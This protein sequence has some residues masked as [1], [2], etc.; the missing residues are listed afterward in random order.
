MEINF[1]GLT[2]RQM[3]LIG[4]EARTLWVGAGT[5]TGKTVAAAIW[6]AIG[7]LAGEPTAWCGPWSARTRTGYKKVRAIL[8]P[9]IEAGEINAN[10]S[11]MRL[12]SKNGGTFEPFTGDNPGAIYGDGIKRFVIDE[13]SRQTQDTYTAAT[14]TTSAAKGSIRLLFNLDLGGQNWA[15]ENLL[16]VQAASP[17]ERDRASEDFMLFPTGDGGLVDDEEI[18]RVRLSGMPT[19]LFEALYLAKIPDTD[20][21]LFHN[22]PWIFANG[23]PAPLGPKA[24]NVYIVSLDTARKRDWNAMLVMDEPL[25]RVVAF[26]RF[27]RLEWE[28]QYDKMQS[29]YDHWG[30]SKLLIDSTGI[31]DPVEAELY[32]RGLNVEGYGFT[33]K[34]RDALVTGLVL[35]CDK[36]AFTVCNGEQFDVLKAE[37]TRFTMLLDG[38]RIRYGVTSG[39]DDAAISMMLL[40]H[41]KSTGNF[42]A[43]QFGRVRDPEEAAASSW[44]VF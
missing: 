2:P 21:N 32:K 5:K 16:R 4:S 35:A 1:D 23:G 20:L 27:H 7:I 14:S 17:E 9:W 43:P 34:S 37:L 40:W 22:L 6:I 30:C 26:Q 36:K 3:E 8:E 13:A 19:P 15:I 38:K 29:M 33:E 44:G 31:G 24:G 11:S 28:M 41:L 39:H 12:E 10:D 42:G 18:E 25:S